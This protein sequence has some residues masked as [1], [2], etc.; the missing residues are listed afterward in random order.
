MAAMRRSLLAVLC[1]VAATLCACRDRRFVDRASAIR[2]LQSHQ[3][4]FDKLAEEWVGPNGPRRP[5]TFCNFNSGKYRWQKYIIDRAGDG[6][7][8]KGDGG[9]KRAANIEEAATISGMPLP[10]LTRWIDITSRDEIYCIE[11]GSDGVVQIMLAGS[12]WSPYGFR[13][14]PKE[15]AGAFSTLRHFVAQG[16]ME[17]TDTKMDQISGRWFYFEARRF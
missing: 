13:Y 11:S 10:L 16:G 2:H 15:D 1:L 7:T 17:N 6:Y 14:A 8:V 3:E 4:E 12:E 9:R 5:A